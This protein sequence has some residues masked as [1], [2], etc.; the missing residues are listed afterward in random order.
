MRRTRRAICQP[1]HAA[2][3][4]PGLTSPPRGLKARGVANPARSGKSLLLLY[5]ICQA[6][7]S[8]IFLFIRTPNQRY[9]LPRPA[10]TEGRFAVVTK[11]GVRDAMDAA[12]S[13]GSSVI[14]ER[15]MRGRRAKERRVR[16]S[17]VVLAP[18]PWRQVGREVS[19]R[20]RWQTTPLHRGERE[21][22]RKTVARGKPVCPGCTCSDY[23]RVLT[24]FG[25]E[26]TGASGTRRPLL[27]E[28]DNEIEK[29]G[30]KHAAGM[31]MCVSSFRGEGDLVLT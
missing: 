23:A 26:A 18:R 31:R 22:D 25:R 8:K 30:Q 21:V 11:R 20:R 19:R 4:L 7:K 14:S 3:P 16:R 17:R 2:R 12:I 9:D 1:C 27:D 24:F 28:R 29:P 5:G 13:G 10:P 6:P 15:V